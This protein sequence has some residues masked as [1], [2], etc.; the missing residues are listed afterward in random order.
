MSIDNRISELLPA[1]VGEEDT[2]I[3]DE[4]NAIV[5]TTKE[6]SET[7]MSIEQEDENLEVDLSTL[8]FNEDQDEEE[9]EIAITGKTFETLYRL[10]QKYEKNFSV[11]GVQ[12]NNILNSKNVEKTES[13]ADYT[14]F[15]IEDQNKFKT[16]HDAFRLVL[17]F[18]SIY[19]RCSP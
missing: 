16:F 13:L 17:K 7:D 3:E 19:A 10:N 1:E 11:E 12:K 2:K 5:K 14:N 18:C 8:P 9:I 4:G 15:G 6:K